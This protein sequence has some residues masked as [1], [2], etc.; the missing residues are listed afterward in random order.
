[1]Y[2]LDI[3]RIAVGKFLGS[4]SRLSGAE[5]ID[6]LF[7]YFINQ[8]PKVIKEVDQIII[9]NALM[10][11]GGQNPA[12]I[13]G[14]QEGIFRKSSALTI[15]QVCGSGLASIIEATKSIRLS[16]ADAV[17]AGGMESMSNA[18]FLINGIR[19]GIKFGN[20]NYLDSILSDGLFCKLSQSLMGKTAENIA[21]RYKISREK[22]DI[23]S[24]QSHLKA[25][26]AIKNRV[27]ENEIIPIKLDKETLFKTDEQPRFDSSLE[28]LSKLKPIFKEG[29]TVTAGNS[30]PLNDGAALCLLV[31]EKILKK[32]DLKPMAR[33]IGYD[34]SG[35]NPAFMGLG[36]YYSIGNLLKKTGF[37]INKVNLFEINE[38]FAAQAIAVIKLLGINGNLVNINGGGIALG[39]PLGASGTRILTTLIHTLRKKD[40]KYG[41][42]SLCIG[43]G[44]G[45]SVLVES[46]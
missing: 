40:L 34:Y 38:A 35:T 12:R 6:P 45:I 41:I 10:A 29:G 14:Y 1:M 37:D 3:K 36:A 23:Y 44:Q 22:Q 30:S 15:N 5:I 2:I 26:K 31:S 27:F 11:G 43:G 32:Y 19:K 8:Y 9:G 39:H 33:I 7:K 46:L 20:Q 17:L 4:I 42:A 21:K 16:D 18:P 13:A 24:H 25:T 28:K